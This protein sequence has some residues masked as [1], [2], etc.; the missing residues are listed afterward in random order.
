MSQSRD[1]AYDIARTVEKLNR[2]RQAITRKSILVADEI[3]ENAELDNKSI[4]LVESEDFI[5]GVLGLLASRLV[6]QYYLPSV[7]ISID[8]PYARGISDPGR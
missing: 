3:I 4:I 8:G 6:D 7:A 2:D 1:E 5:P